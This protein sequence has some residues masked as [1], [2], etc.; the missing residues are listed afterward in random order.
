MYLKD[1]T[2]SPI[3]DD[4]EAYI[5]P[6]ERV[7]K[8]PFVNGLYKDEAPFRLLSAPILARLNENELVPEN[9]DD[10]TELKTLFEEH[11]VVLKN[12][13]TLSEVQLHFLSDSK[14]RTL[15]FSVWSKIDR[16]IFK[17]KLYV[18]GFT[19]AFTLNPVSYCSIKKSVFDE[20]INSYE[21]EVN[22]SY[23]EFKKYFSTFFNTEFSIEKMKIKKA[24]RLKYNTRYLSDKIIRSVDLV[25]QYSPILF[26]LNVLK[27]NGFDLIPFDFTYEG[28]ST[29]D[30]AKTIIEM[31]SEKT[32]RVNCH[33]ENFKVLTWTQV[34]DITAKLE[35]PDSLS[36]YEAPMRENMDKD[37]RVY[38]EKTDKLFDQDF[39]LFELAK[40]NIVHNL[41]MNNQNII[42]QFD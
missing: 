20:I 28:I 38:I 3:E 9:K 10:Y 23:P 18:K 11:A 8:K 22:G 7:I 13:M 21:D 34:M 17:E 19:K 32:Q 30:F 6:I 35:C 36:D 2:N 5:I 4:E 39:S 16:H 42:I 26:V 40:S 25:E 24:E 12:D 29:C 33:F 27:S 37:N 31:E 41:K 1:I 15:P 14:N